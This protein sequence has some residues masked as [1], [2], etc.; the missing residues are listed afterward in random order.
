M[1]LSEWNHKQVTQKI[2]KPI[3]PS[4]MTERGYKPNINQNSCR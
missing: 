1:A 2:P 4:Y 3:K